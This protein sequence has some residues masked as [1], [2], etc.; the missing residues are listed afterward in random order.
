MPVGPADQRSQIK[1]F[2]IAPSWTRLL[3]SNTVFNKQPQ[4]LAAPRLMSN[5]Q[6]RDRTADTRIFSPVLYQLSYLPLRWV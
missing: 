2:N 6:R 5:G 4:W 1:T 3:S